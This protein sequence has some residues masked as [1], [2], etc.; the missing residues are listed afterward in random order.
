[1]AIVSAAKMTPGQVFKGVYKGEIEL[2]YGPGYELIDG[3]DSTVL[4]GSKRLG[5]ALEKVVPGTSVT[6]TYT[7]KENVTITS[8]KSKYKGKTVPAHLFTVETV[9]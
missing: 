8:D 3:K 1:M 6:I 5:Y 7:G 2:Q 4:T 9:D